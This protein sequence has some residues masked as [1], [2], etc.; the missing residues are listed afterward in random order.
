MKMTYTFTSWLQFQILQLVNDMKKK[1]IIFLGIEITREN[2][3]ESKNDRTSKNRKPLSWN[4]IKAFYCFA[5]HSK[6]FLLLGYHVKKIFVHE[7]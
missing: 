1:R 2:K 5:C 4:F 6:P 7:D 3:C